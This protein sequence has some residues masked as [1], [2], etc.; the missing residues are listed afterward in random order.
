MQVHYFGHSAVAL[1]Q[2]EHTVLVDP[3]LAHNPL[4]GKMPDFAHLS[5]IVCTHGHEDHVGDAVEL[6]KKYGA[7]VVGVYELANHLESLGATAIPCGLGGRVNHAWG[8]SKL[9]P[10]FHSSSHGGKYTGQ[11]AGVILNFGEVTVY[12]AGDTCVFGDM[13]LI[14][15][16]YH[17]DIALLPMGGHFTMDIHEAVK[18]VELLSPN[19]VIPMHFGTFP[20]LSEDP[21]EFKRQVEA[22]GLASVRILKPD[23]VFEFAAVAR[24]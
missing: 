22:K 9:V 4:F 3:F 2:G 10:A 19:L 5:T 21:A 7:P 16:L 8:W 12:H 11:P 23:E 20:P 15:E 1:S 24:H 17:P 14:A 6:S 13:K 18:A